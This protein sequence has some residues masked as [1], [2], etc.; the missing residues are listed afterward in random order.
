M[1]FL[2]IFLIKLRSTTSIFGNAKHIMTDTMRKKMVQSV[3]K[4]LYN[5]LL[6][7]TK[8]KKLN[9]LEISY[10]SEKFFHQRIY[11]RPFKLWNRIEKLWMEF[12]KSF[13]LAQLNIFLKTVNFF[14][15]TPTQYPGDFS[16]K[17]FQNL[18]DKSIFLLTSRTLQWPITL[19]FIF[20]KKFYSTKRF[21]Y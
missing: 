11:T 2:S 4:F 20:R 13:N 5:N 8:L 9:S 1:P 3:E 10:G 16:M 21:S 7:W 19:K 12:W 15:Y 14:A 17:W 6:I 18:Y